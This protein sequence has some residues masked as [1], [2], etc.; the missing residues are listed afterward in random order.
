MCMSCCWEYYLIAFLLNFIEFGVENQ[1]NNKQS[2]KNLIDDKMEVGMDFGWLLDRFLMDFGA[3]LGVKLGPSWHQDRRKWGTKMMSKNHQ[4]SGAAS[5]RGWS[6]G[7]TQV[8]RRWYAVV[9]GP[10][11]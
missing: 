6:A 11:P 7:G 1:K 9:G 3:K 8:V 5:G 4:K 2:T 10:G